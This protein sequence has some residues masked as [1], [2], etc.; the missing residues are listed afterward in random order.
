MSALPPFITATL[1]FPYTEGQKFISAL[2][3]RGGNTW[4]LPNLAERT[5][6]PTSTEQ[7]LHPQK[8]IDVE[9]PDPVTLPEPPPGYGRLT[10]GTFGEFQTAKWVGLA[11]PGGAD[12]AAGWGGDHYALYRDGDDELLIMR[13]VWDTPA[14]E[15]EFAAVLQDVLKAAG[16]GIYT[17]VDDDTTVVLG[18]DAAAVQRLGSPSRG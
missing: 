15:Q 3:E 8:W 2:Y 14:D 18:T 5:R 12:V 7:I 10:A 4:T 9:E 6:P 13:W 11:G 17:N 16:E 1:L